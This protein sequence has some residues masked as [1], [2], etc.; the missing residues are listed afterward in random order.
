[1]LKTSKSATAIRLFW[2]GVGTHITKI[3]IG[4]FIEHLRTQCRR[5]KPE[6][7][8]RLFINHW[9]IVNKALERELGKSA[10]SGGQILFGCF[11][12]L[13]QPFIALFYTWVTFVL[14]LVNMIYIYARGPCQSIP[15]YAVWKSGEKPSEIGDWEPE[16][17]S[18][19]A[20]CTTGTLSGRK[21][22]Y[23]RSSLWLVF[24]KSISDSC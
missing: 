12:S 18:A 4:K 1:M 21:Q 17:D 11:L 7:D 14:C 24:F 8:W 15:T 19:E 10:S 9:L 6:T 22:H 5:R 13:R 16:K 23:F 3:K 20:F 2:H